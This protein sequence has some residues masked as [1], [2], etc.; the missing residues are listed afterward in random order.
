M[1][2]RLAQVI[3]ISPDSDASARRR[4]SP[5]GSVP[6]PGRR[7]C[8]RGRADATD[9]QQDN[10]MDI[11]SLPAAGFVPGAA[12]PA[13]SLGVAGPSAGPGGNLLCAQDHTREPTCVNRI[14][15]V[16]T[17]R[18]VVPQVTRATWDFLRLDILCA[19]CVSADSFAHVT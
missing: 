9:H 2:I 4:T 7:S 1:P 18:Q 5:G 17:G 3:W 13:V 8:T 12:A 6:P 10:R 15:I 14:G 19:R 11:R 16:R